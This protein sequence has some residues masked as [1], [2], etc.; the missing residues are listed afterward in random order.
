MLA[1]PPVWPDSVLVFSDT[2]TDIKE[3]IDKA[4]LDLQDKSGH[5][6]EKR[7]ALLFKPGTYDVDFIV[8]Y[9]V[10]VLGLGEQVSD[11]QFVGKK[12]PYSPCMDPHGSGSLDTFWK[13]M[14]NI[15]TENTMWAV[16][17]A[18]PIRRIEVNGDLLLHEH[19]L[20]ASGG[21]M[22]QVKVNKQLQIGSQQQFCFRNCEFNTKPDG[23]A[24]SVVYSGCI[25]APPS[26]G[27]SIS[28]PNPDLAVSTITETPIIAEK[29]FIIIDNNGKYNLQIPKVKSNTVGIDHTIN[30]CKTIPFE[31]I[32]V[33]RVEIDTS[34]TIQDKLDDGYHIC[35]T[36]GI[37]NLT[38]TLVVKHNKQV[39]LGIGLATL[40]AC[41]TGKP[42]IKVENY[43]TDVRIAGLMLE[44][45]EIDVFENSCI[46]Q[47]G[48]NTI[49]NSTGIISETNIS[50]V[51][52]DIF[53][54]V[55]ENINV[56][57]QTIMKIYSDNVVMDNI[58]TWKG[59]HIKLMP[60]EEALPN[61]KYHLVKS[62]EC[63]VDTCLEVFG[64]N[65]F[66]YG[67]FAEHALKNL[68]EWYGN[69]GFV[70]FFQSEL[71]YEVDQENYGDKNYCAYKI[72]NN[73]EKHLLI[74]AGIYSFFRDNE[75]IVNSA[76]IAPQKSGIVIQNPYTVYLNGYG[77]IRH[78]LNNIG[79]S[80]GSNIQQKLA[81]IN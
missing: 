39:L 34:K 65:V 81:Y 13:S 61:E 50:C 75:V 3:R 20:Y 52:S 33:T 11:T 48:D 55:C 5:F 44:A 78:I 76:I 80:V 31:Y 30:N 38:E 12:G 21:F 4:T 58:W 2:D 37:Y 41:S 70:A 64:N 36:P 54:R 16:S 79:N 57:V 59:D 9:Y 25:G 45:S 74:A 8:G 43:L 53:I 24:W 23:C 68:V 15:H 6:S 62:G 60:N 40:K 66:A 49:E 27:R 14:E 56:S 18:A 72:H 73:I 19:G 42:C 47:L 63:I 1:N 77:G 7:V 46:I 67:L 22:S 10:Q 35:F 29:P 26:S 51:L 32:Y 28:N 71:P 69:N 17:Q